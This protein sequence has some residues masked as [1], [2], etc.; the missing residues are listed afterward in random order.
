MA[1][2]DAMENQLKPPPLRQ[3]AWPWLVLAAFILAV[4]LACLWM[5]KEVQ[6]VKRIKASTQE[7][8]GPSS[9]NP[10]PARAPH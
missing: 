10:L 7:Y 2:H 6:R 8:Y 3:H 9:T 4:V 5:F 1:D